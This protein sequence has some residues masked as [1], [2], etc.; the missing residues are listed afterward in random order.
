MPAPTV[1][2]DKLHCI[3]L[4]NGCFSPDTQTQAGDIDLM[5]DSFV[6]HSPA[7]GMAIH[8]HGGL[9]SLKSGMGIADRLSTEYERAG[10]YPIFFL[11]ESGAL[12]T[13]AN[14]LRDIGKEPIFHE[15][16]RKVVE[17]ALGRLGGAI[18]GRGGSGATV[19]PVQVAQEV[20]KWFADASGDPP[21]ADFKLQPQAAGAR[22]AA[23]VDLEFESNV[24]ADLEMDP[25]IKSALEQVEQGLFPA[26]Q[27]EDSPGGG[28][29]AASTTLM[30]PKALDEILESRQPGEKG[31]ISTAKLAW[32]IIKLVRA[33]V[34]R[35]LDGR[36]HGLYGT[37][38]EEIYRKMY[39]DKIGQ[40]F[41]WSQMKKDTADAF[42]S[43][44]A[45]G[46]EPGGTEFLSRLSARIK[47]GEHIPRI[48]LIGH[49]TGAVYIC[50]FLEA[51]DKYL[52]ADVRFDIVF[53]APA[54]DFQL[55]KT[56]MEKYAHRV[57]NFRMFAMTDA[58]E[59]DDPMAQDF[60]GKKLASVVYPHSLLYFVS[61]LLESGEV[62]TPILGMQRFFGKT[63]TFNREDYPEIQWARDTLSSQT[64]WSISD[65]A[66][67]R[68]STSRQHGSF[69][70]DETT[71]ISLRHII[72]L[73]YQ[74]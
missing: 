64:V 60:L 1:A 40:A 33:V 41:F 21:Y 55:F 3:H 42:A 10:A 52:P 28:Q 5:L 53:L 38:V 63:D 9:V 23:V 46:K 18:G 45:P 72:E 7:A 68:R 29:L 19:D 24:M 56:A 54:V 16:V 65:S 58:L 67:G 22:S 43:V 39:V 59:K 27:T 6:K 8:F 50:H 47:G 13:V 49:S 37:V 26:G 61:G 11:W 36:D 70:N 74:P 30:E 71:L 17:F 32:A 25:R 73:G 35:F 66:D 2:L 57:G 4:E 44:G 14:N 20:D 51:A 48:T 69:D 34:S 12:E 31:L 62:D 15:L